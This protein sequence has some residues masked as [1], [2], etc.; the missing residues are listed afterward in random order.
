M[1]NSVR[2]SVRI[3]VRKYTES[4]GFLNTNYTKNFIKEANKMNHWVK[5][6]Y[7][8]IALETDAWVSPYP[9]KFSGVRWPNQSE[10]LKFYR[11]VIDMLS[12]NN[13]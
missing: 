10:Q 13:R 5:Q 2:G 7:V 8:E 11:Q 9:T 6:I 12:R 3:V 4:L 1:Y